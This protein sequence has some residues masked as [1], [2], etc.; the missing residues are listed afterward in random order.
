MK[1]KTEKERKL[2]K[3]NIVLWKKTIK[4]TNIWQDYQR[5][6]KDTN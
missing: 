1:L 4:L 6:E 3:Q 5:K 2:V